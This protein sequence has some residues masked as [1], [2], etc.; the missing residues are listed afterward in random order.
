MIKI[1]N[2]EGN[3][4]IEFVRIYNERIRSSGY[5]MSTLQS[6]VK[7]ATSSDMKRNVGYSDI[8][9]VFSRLI[10]YLGEAKCDNDVYLNCVR[11]MRCAV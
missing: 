11:M 8:N 6:I 2:Y 7:L 9:E 3:L 5:K 1:A 10:R 4:M